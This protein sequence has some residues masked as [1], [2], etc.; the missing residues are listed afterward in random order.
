VDTRAGNILLEELTPWLLS[1]QVRN[2]QRYK[3]NDEFF[4][5]KITGPIHNLDLSRDLQ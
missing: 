4:V 3:K 1:N 5:C 2:Y